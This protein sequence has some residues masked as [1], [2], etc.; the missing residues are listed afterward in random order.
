MHFYIIIIDLYK[1]ISIINWNYIVLNLTSAAA[2]P[3]TQYHHALG[4]ASDKIVENYLSFKN[5]KLK[6]KDE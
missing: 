1:R 4:K 5:N 3:P 6:T 2:Y